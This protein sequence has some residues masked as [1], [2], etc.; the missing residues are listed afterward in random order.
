MR[1]HAGWG[2]VMWNAFAVVGI[3]YVLVKAIEWTAFWWAAI[4]KIHDEA[5]KR[6]VDDEAKQGIK[7]WF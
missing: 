5:M 6:T 4:N 1:Q 3:F 2:A 7:G